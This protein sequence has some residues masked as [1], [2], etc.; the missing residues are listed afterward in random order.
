M[1]HAMT[2]AVA[3]AGGIIWDVLGPD[4]DSK[5]D[6]LKFDLFRIYRYRSRNAHDHFAPRFFGYSGT[7]CFRRGC[8]MGRVRMCPTGEADTIGH[9]AQSASESAQPHSI[10]FDDGGRIRRRTCSVR[11]AQEGRSC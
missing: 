5:R 3:I 2:R 8:P 7:S 6:F 11:P 9:K 10:S 4:F 1:T